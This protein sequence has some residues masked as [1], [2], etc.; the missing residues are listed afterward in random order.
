MREFDHAIITFFN[1]FAQRCPLF[2]SIV[3]FFTN[4]D[5]VKG[6]VILAGLW[7]AWFCSGPNVRNNRSYLL[8]ALLGSLVTLALARVL[9]H[10]LPLRVRPILD[11]SLHFRPPTGL[12]DQSNWTIWSS[13]PSDHAALFCALL[14]G[15][16]LASRRAG[17]VLLVYVLVA[18]CF[19]RIYIGIH[20]P[21]DILAGAALGVFSVLL[22]SWRK[23]R[24]LWTNPILNWVERWPGL[25]Y[26]LLFLISFEIATLFWDVRTFL[27][28]FDI[29]V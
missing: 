3:V 24:E 27:Y 14:T 9:A 1:Q 19:P 21:S 22:L 4:S 29:S 17:I 12:P 8:S 15:I 18:I 28:I 10:A 2:D 23:V 26:A 7:F 5:L 25:S 20:Y 13:F 16:W 6:G 11:P